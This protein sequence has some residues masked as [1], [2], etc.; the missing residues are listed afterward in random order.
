M[1]R[2][3]GE[4]SMSEAE[5]AWLLRA[6]QRTDGDCWGV[7]GPYPSLP[8]NG[9]FYLICTRRNGVVR[10]IVTG[11]FDWVLTRETAE[12]LEWGVTRRQGT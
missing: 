5:A 12:S 9:G 3:K 1:L 7:A 2:T 10:H 11:L 8:V 6:I 4:W